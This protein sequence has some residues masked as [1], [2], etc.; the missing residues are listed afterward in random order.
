MSGNVAFF[1][2]VCLLQSVPKLL[3][4]LLKNQTKKQPQI[5]CALYN[6]ILSFIHPS[7]EI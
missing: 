1:A 3:Q 2:V 6:R 4:L 5:S 7:L